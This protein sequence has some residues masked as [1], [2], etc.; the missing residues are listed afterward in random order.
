MLDKNGPGDKNGLDDSDGDGA[1][2]GGGVGGEDSEDWCGEKADRPPPPPLPPS[3]RPNMNG[4]ISN[5]PS[6]SDYERLRKLQLKRVS[7]CTFNPCSVTHPH[8]FTLSSLHPTTLAL[9][10]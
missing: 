8:L 1:G 9:G 10:R 2:G 4:K 7:R 5:Q 6:M 3:A